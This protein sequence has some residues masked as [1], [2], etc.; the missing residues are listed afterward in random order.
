MLIWRKLS[1]DNNKKNQ[2]YVYNVSGTAQTLYIFQLI[3]S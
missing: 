1:S 3:K 2:Y